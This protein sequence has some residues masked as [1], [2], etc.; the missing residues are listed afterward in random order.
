MSARTPLAVDPGQYPSLDLGPEAMFAENDLHRRADATDAVLWT[1]DAAAAVGPLAPPRAPLDIPVLRSSAWPDARA[2]CDSALEYASTFEKSFPGVAQVISQ[3]DNVYVAGGAANW[4]L[5]YNNGDRNPPGDI[6]IFVVGIDPQDSRALWAKV[7]EVR[8]ALRASFGQPRRE[9]ISPGVLTM[10]FE[11]LTIQVILRAFATVS[12]LLHGFDI[13]SA[14]I[15]YDGVTAYM[16]Y[17]AVW[18]YVHMVN[19]INPAYRSTTYELRVKKYFERGYGLG[20]LGMAPAALAC[21]RLEL[22]HIILFVYRINGLAARGRVRL[23]WEKV[24]AVSDY[25]PAV[26]SNAHTNYGRTLYNIRQILIG[27]NRYIHRLEGD[28][29]FEEFVAASPT[30]DWIVSRDTFEGSLDAATSTAAGNSNRAPGILRRV[31]QLPDAV[32][33]RFLRH[34]EMAGPAVA[35]HT[36]ATLLAPYRA[37][38]LAAY[39][40]APREIPWWIVTDPSR[41]YTVSLNPR[42]E[43][44]A[45]WYGA[46]A[47]R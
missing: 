1:F 2:C 31:F 19:V 38:L 40:A 8:A 12:A 10:Y 7:G 42:I 28:Q 47:R 6:D 3:V 4:P 36:A 15:A 21:G 27:D 22:P 45:T 25:T 46:A 44:A 29:S 41:Q 39:E 16:T 33:A 23:R 32:L 34:M 17:A 18:A 13:P 9:Y 35:V 37:A 26:S 14:A 11:S 43:D 30:L 24:P 5:V 20:L